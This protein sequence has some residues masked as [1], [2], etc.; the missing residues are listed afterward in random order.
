MKKQEHCIMMQQRLLKNNETEQEGSEMQISPDYTIKLDFEDSSYEL[1]S[2]PFE[3]VKEATIK[4]EDDICFIEYESLDQEAKVSTKDAEQRIK[5]ELATQSESQE[6]NVTTEQNQQNISEQQAVQQPAQHQFKN[7]NRYNS[8]CKN[9]Q[10]NNLSKKH[11]Q[12]IQVLRLM[13]GA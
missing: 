1:H 5:E 9:N 10:Y 11:L 2:F 8:R 6:N 7:S 13:K 12:Q 3:D 4:F